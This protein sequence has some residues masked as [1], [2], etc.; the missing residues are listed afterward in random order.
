MDLKKGLVGLGIIL[1]DHSGSI[2]AANAQKLVAG[3]SVTIA[4]ALAMLK[5]IQFALATS[6]LPTIVE[7]DSLEVVSIINNP[8]V[9]FSEVGLIISD[10]MDLLGRCPSSKVLYVPR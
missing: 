9:Y 8:S 2:M 5:G 6:L 10:I 3:Y 1:I 4:E 7:T